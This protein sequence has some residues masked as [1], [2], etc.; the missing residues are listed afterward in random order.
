[1]PA[2]QFWKFLLETGVDVEEAIVT[3]RAAPLVHTAM[4]TEQI[5]AAVWM[6]SSIQCGHPPDVI[7]K[8]WTTVIIA[9]NEISNVSLTHSLSALKDADGRAVEKFFSVGIIDPVLE[10][11]MALYASVYKVCSDLFVRI[12]VNIL[13][14]VSHVLTSHCTCADSGSVSRNFPSCVAVF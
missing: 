13:Y 10:S 3:S 12:P 4:N 2:V 7:E 5:R 14:L 11:I 8:D 1:M 6:S 9:T